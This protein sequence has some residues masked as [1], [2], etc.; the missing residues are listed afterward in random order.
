MIEQQLHP[1]EHGLDR[2]TVRQNARVVY[3]MSR[4]V[5][6]GGFFF[7]WCRACVVIS[8]SL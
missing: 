1:T 2:Y 3:S 5:D 8:L 6:S 7:L 4:V